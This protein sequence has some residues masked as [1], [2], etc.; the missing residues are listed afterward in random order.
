MA[1]LS[2]AFFSVAAAASATAIPGRTDRHFM[3][4]GGSARPQFQP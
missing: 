1:P 3:T 4:R 2:K